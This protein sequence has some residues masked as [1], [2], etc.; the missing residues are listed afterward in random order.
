MPRPMVECSPPLTYQKQD[1]EET[2][3][4]HPN[5]VGDDTHLAA[6][7]ITEPDPLLKI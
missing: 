6:R 2:E 1:Y 5:P 3:Y 4:D 7:R